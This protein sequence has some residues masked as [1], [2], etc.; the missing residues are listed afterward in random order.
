MIYISFKKEKNEIKRNY[1]YENKYTDY[2]NFRESLLQMDYYQFSIELS[3]N[4]NNKN[5]IQMIELTSV[6]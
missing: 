3:K 1:Y 5:R 4:L 2:Q 6:F